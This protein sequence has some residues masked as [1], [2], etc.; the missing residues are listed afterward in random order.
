[1]TSE[2]LHQRDEGNGVLVYMIDELR[3][4]VDEGLA[5]GPSR[6]TSVTDIKAEARRRLNA[7]IENMR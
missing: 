2:T 4:L 6:F 5:S 3:N 7:A 1:M